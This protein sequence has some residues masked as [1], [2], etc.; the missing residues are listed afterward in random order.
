MIWKLLT[1]K[2]VSVRCLGGVVHSGKI[3]A[4]APD[5]IAIG[6]R[7]VVSLPSI[8]SFDIRE[9]D[10]NFVREL[11]GEPFSTASGP[12]YDDKTTAT[13]AALHIEPG[14]TSG[15]PPILGIRL[16]DPPVDKPLY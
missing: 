14:T 1:G 15:P 8:V 9:V 5:A 16:D 4:V 12:V 10:D 6:E 2:F 3:I 13:E 7:T 11:L